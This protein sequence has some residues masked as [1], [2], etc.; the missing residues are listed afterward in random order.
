ML[1]Y[2]TLALSASWASS[3]QISLDGRAAAHVYDGHGGLSA[4]ASSRLLWDYPEAQRADVLD[5]LFL[6][7]HGLS[8]HTIK[9]EI[10]GDAQSTDGTEPSHEHARG[11]LSCTRGYEIFLLQEAKRRNPDIV[12][13]GLS[14][15]APGWINNGTTF[16]GEEMM[17]YQSDW[18]ACIKKELGFWVDYI[19]SWN[20]RPYG[21]PEY[22]K[23]LRAA[24]DLQ[25]ASTTKI[26]IPDGGYDASIL[27]DAAADP[28]FNASA[29]ATLQAPPT[30]LAR[31]PTSN[32]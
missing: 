21:G 32:P 17:S 31:P 30:P 20:E 4:G 2:A 19:G 13:F 6:P 15:G 16:F 3:A 14:W 9:V 24:L 29:S 10:G 11:D 23:G 1:R 27:A 28:A 12:T 5:M 22:I 25:G 26:V 18:V 8:L 7:Q